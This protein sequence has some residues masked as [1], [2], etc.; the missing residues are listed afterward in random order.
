MGQFQDL[1]AQAAIIRD[2]QN[3]YQNTSLRVGRMFVDILE[4]LEK[5]LPDENVKPET[6]TV[7]AT[8]TS[9]KLKFSTL[10]SDGSV[11][12][13]ELDLPIATDTKAGVMS[14]ELM[15]GIKDQ[16]SQLSLKVDSNKTDSDN[17]ISELESENSSIAFTTSYY[18]NKIIKELYLEGTSEDE[19][20]RIYIAKGADFQITRVSDSTLVARASSINSVQ[21]AEVIEYNSSGIHGY[22]VFDWDNWN[23][24]WIVTGGNTNV[25]TTYLT[26]QSYNKL[27]LCPIIKMF[28]NYAESKRVKNIEDNLIIRNYVL[29]NLGENLFNPNDPYISKINNYLYSGYIPVNE[30]KYLKLLGY[31]TGGITLRFYDDSF[32]LINS[33]TSLETTGVYSIFEGSSYVRFPITDDYKSKNVIAVVGDD[34]SKLVTY[35]KLPFTTLFNS[36][37]SQD[38]QKLSVL[39]DRLGENI[40][41]LINDRLF[42]YNLLDKSK[43]VSGYLSTSENANSNDGYRCTVFYIQVKPGQKYKINGLRTDFSFMYDQNKSTL[44]SFNNSGVLSDNTITIPENVY[45]IRVTCQVVDID[46][47][48]VINDE[49][50]DFAFNGVLEYGKYIVNNSLDFSNIEIPLK[51]NTV[52]PSKCTFFSIGKNL[53]NENDPDFADGYYLNTSTGLSSNANASYKTSGYIPITKEQI[54]KYVNVS[55]NGR[56]IETR[57]YVFCNSE[58]KVIESSSSGTTKAYLIP[59]KAAYYRCTVNVSNTKVQ[60]EISDVGSVT[61]YSPYKLSISNDYLPD[62]IGGDSIQV[63]L[64][65]EICIA[66]GRTIELYNKQVAFCGNYDNFHFKYTATNSGG[67]SIGKLYVDKFS[68]PVTSPDQVGEYTLVLEVLDNNLNTVS[69]ANSVIR[70]VDKP[71]NLSPQN[72]MMV[73]DSLGNKPWLPEIRKLANDILGEQK[74]TW[75]GT[76]KAYA[77]INSAYPDYEEFCKNEG[78]SG[79]TAGY[80]IS[81]GAKFTQ[82]ILNVTGVAEAPARKKQYYIS[83]KEGGNM[84]Y[85]VEE[86]LNEEDLPYEDNG[87]TISK[88]SM[89]QVVNSWSTPD[90]QA[91]GGTI[92]AK[93]TSQSG[94][95]SITYTSWETPNSNPFWNPTGG[96]DGTGA[97]DFNWYFE[98]ND[99]PIPTFMFT[100]LGMNGHNADNLYEFIRLYRE[101]VPVSK[102]VAMI[103]HFTGDLN[104]DL[105]KKKSIFEFNVAICDKLK[106]M[107]GVYVAPVF[108]THDSDH[109]FFNGEENVNPRNDTIKLL[110]IGDITHP[111]NPG[112]MQY[113]DI[114]FSTWLAYCND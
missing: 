65:S 10:T 88:I 5:A 100:M 26:K 45:Y 73:G 59:E 82:I 54:G 71:S 56:R 16:I 60:V 67:Q 19:Q 106:G 104:T 87:G 51:D 23:D 48:A 105:S 31:R 95:N 37:A 12:N 79:W 9:Y 6:L 27:E 90:G 24:S 81:D 114:G 1:K 94:D 32:N 74:I 78:R 92:T 107:D 3:D 29:S 70:V 112:Y 7:E 17:K 80:Y 40:F 18:G 57:F 36:I 43:F 84:T 15:K 14:P 35:L 69:T 77:G 41:E 83:A 110:S 111:Q 99:I 13:R 58:K 91:T 55:N 96:E 113:A 75:V 33:S 25:P 50:W 108:I 42:T 66:V 103:P 102:V 68:I 98:Q 11:K 61:S 52:T 22:V 64:P 53:Y 86:V 46:K 30:K 21:F 97:V 34:N 85:E 76:L 2:E 109:N 28:L 38:L 8:E 39:Y 101:Q 89:N 63:F 49:N 4:Q 44:Y 72:L 20:Y 93:D 62:D 47:V